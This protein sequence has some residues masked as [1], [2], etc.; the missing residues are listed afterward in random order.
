MDELILAADLMVALA[1]TIKRANETAQG[2]VH[3]CDPWDSRIQ[4]YRGLPDLHKALRIEAPMKWASRDCDEYPVQA[5]FEYRGITFLQIA[6]S[7]EELV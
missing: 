1:G 4:V 5:S 7:K 6:K 3:F 2:Q